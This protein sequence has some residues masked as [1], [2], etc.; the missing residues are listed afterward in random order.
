MTSYENGEIQNKMLT[1]KNN[2]VC[3]ENRFPTDSF[4]PIDLHCD[5][6]WEDTLTETQNLNDNKYAIKEMILLNE[7]DENICRITYNAQTVF[8]KIKQ[9][10]EYS[11]VTEKRGRNIQTIIQ[12]LL[13]LE[14]KYEKS[15]MTKSMI[16]SSIAMM[17]WLCVK[18]NF[19][20]AKKM[21]RESAVFVSLN[22]LKHGK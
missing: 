19:V 13:D 20:S 17:D 10:D 14:N 8:T 16:I 11:C 7:R 15:T 6:S 21:R 18:K 5:E 1:T 22:V 3:K 4:Y 9:M 2:D 12:V